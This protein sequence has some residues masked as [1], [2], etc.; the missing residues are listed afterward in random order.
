MPKNREMAGFELINLYARKEPTKDSASI[1]LG[2]GQK[3]DTVLY[4][5]PECTI[6]AARWPWH[7]SNCPRR[8]QKRVTLNCFRWNLVWTDQK[9]I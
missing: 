8:G 6:V 7:Y 9:P 1:F 3:K 4:R 2:L 5:D